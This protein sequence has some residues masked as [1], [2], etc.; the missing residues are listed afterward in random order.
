[1]IASFGNEVGRRKL[2]GLRLVDEGRRI[3]FQHGEVALAD[4]QEHRR[5]PLGDVLDRARAPHDHDVAEE[6]IRTVSRHQSVTEPFPVFPGLQVDRGA[7]ADDARDRTRCQ[8]MPGKIFRVRRQEQREMSPGTVAHQVDPLRVAALRGDVPL[9]PGERGGDILDLCGELVLRCEPM[10]QQSTAET[11][12]LEFLANRDDRL[13]TPRVPA[14][15]VGKYHS[16]EA[17][18]LGEV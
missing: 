16:G 12:A 1:V 15:A 9:Y 3:S 11:E 17:R 10:A 18:L 5:Q 14:A 7:E 8:L 2:K 4:D 6:R 13:A